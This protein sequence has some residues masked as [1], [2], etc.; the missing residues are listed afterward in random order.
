MAVT[1]RLAAASVLALVTAGCT[2]AE[3]PRGWGTPHQMTIARTN[4]PRS[5]N[6]LFEGEQGDADLTQL[7]AEPL[8]GLNSQNKIVPVVAS[9]VPSLANGDISRDGRT[10]TYHLRRDE[11]FADGIPL[12]SRD[13]AFTYRAIMDRR[14]PVG[15]VQRYRI[16]ERLDTPDP[17][18]VVLH[19][20]RRWA[21]AVTALFA[22]T[23]FIYGILP[24][25]AFASTDVTHADWNEHPFGSGPFRVVR[26][27]RGDNIVLEPNAYARRKPHLLQL[28]LKIVPD[29]NTARLLLFAHAVDVVGYLTD[30]QAVQT[31]SAPEIQLVR[32]QKNSVEYAEFQTQ[33]PPTDDLR[34]RRALLDAIDTGAIAQKVALGLWPRASTEIPPMLWAH[35]SSITPPSY[36]PQRAAAEL[37][38]AG[39]EMQNGRRVKA[40]RPLE[41]QV[42]YFS[43][44]DEGRDDA[45]LI[46][47]DLAN[48]GV[49]AIL[50]SYPS[51][52]YP[53][54]LSS[55]R[56]NLA[57][58]GWTG[59]SDPEQS[60]IYKCDPLTPNDAHWCDQHYD[61]LFDEQ[62]QT[63]DQARRQVLFDA[64]Q[65]TVRDATLFV[66]L[67][68][69]GDYS[70]INP[71][72]R[73]WNP[74]MLF[75]YSNS[76]N[77]DVQPP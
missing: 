74:D 59:G 8:V 75:E 9:R 57:W 77:W 55:G 63:L 19:L 42:A 71:A 10:I 30:S 43:S 68:Y 1:R 25:H 41:I 69:A 29:R 18:T 35:D 44:D 34:V 67:I 2:H 11:R 17:H 52:I 62:S 51:T 6:P 66:P 40:G 70:A 37:D 73:G 14:N 76:E 32:T 60:E 38:A 53:N 28:A 39:W 5:L 49:R 3:N 24:A 48:V 23:D 27:R 21:A 64:I 31:R 65:R 47:K 45:T 54:V 56:F 15:S 16:I 50:R 20:R 13:V 22:E 12:T 72:V 61:K 7:Y 33:R 46:Q 4:D 36:N 58:G 26:W